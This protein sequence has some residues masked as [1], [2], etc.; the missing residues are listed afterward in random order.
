MFPRIVNNIHI[1][2]PASTKG[3]KVFLNGKRLPVKSFK[4]YVDLFIKVPALVDKPCPPS[5]FSLP[6]HISTY[7]PL[8]ASPP[9]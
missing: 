8:D 1:I 3:V 4:D 6:L 2:L 9:H 5:Y 7:R